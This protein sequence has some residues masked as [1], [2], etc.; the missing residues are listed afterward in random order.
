[1]PDAAG[2]RNAFRLCPAW[3]LGFAAVLLCACSPMH[4][5]RVVLAT[6]YNSVAS[7][8]DS[9]PQLGAWGDRIEPGMKV[10]AVSH[11]LIDAGLDRGTR[12]RI[13]GFDEEFVVLDRM[14]R[15]WKNKI[16]IY[17]GTDVKAARKFGKREVTISW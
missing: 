16:D 15:R 14:H 12:V 1:V 17:M 4:E 8:T 6:A 11:D 5:Q 10:I 2:R 3:A 7:Q 13:E 9:K